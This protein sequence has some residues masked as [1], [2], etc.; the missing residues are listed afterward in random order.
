M[1]SKIP[2]PP[3]FIPV[4]RFDQATGLC[5]GMLVPSSRNEPPAANRE[6]FGIFPSCM[7]CRS[8]WGSIPSIP[9]MMSFFAPGEAE[10]ARW[11][12]TNGVSRAST[13]SAP[14]MR[15]GLQHE[16]PSN[17]AA[18][19]GKRNKIPVLIDTSPLRREFRNQLD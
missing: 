5:G 10:A 15:S 4:I 12:V 13:K 11:Q 14:A 9:R 6:K 19:D 2:C 8:S 16:A 3:A 1:K 17:T 7:N 18:G